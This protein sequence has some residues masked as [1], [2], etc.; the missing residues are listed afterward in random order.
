MYDE[1]Y[2]F[3]SHSF[4]YYDDDDVDNYYSC[5]EQQAGTARIY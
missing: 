4:M 5:D 1:K 2:V 3:H